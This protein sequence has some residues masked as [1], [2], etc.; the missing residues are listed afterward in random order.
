MTIIV[1]ALASQAHSTPVRDL[2]SKARRF[3]ARVLLPRHV[4]RFVVEKYVRKAIRTAAWR[5]LR[6]ESRALLL[7]LRRFQ[8]VVKSM[9][10]KSILYDIFVE[11]ELSTL[12]GRALFY[13][14]IQ[15]IRNGLEQVLGDLKRVLTLGIFYL[16]TPTHYRFYG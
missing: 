15:A 16:N 3:I 8:G 5:S 11:I 7:A 14:F 1:S 13:G 9:V 4:D 12:R 2:V 10:L 6:V